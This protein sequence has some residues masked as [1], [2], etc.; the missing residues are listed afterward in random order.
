MDALGQAGQAQRAIESE[1]IAADKA[2]F[3]EARD[4][5][6]KMAQYKMGL[7]SG[8]PVATQVNTQ[9]TNPI[10]DWL[11]SSKGIA[12]LLNKFGTA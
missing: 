5:D 2:Q 3:D 6:K 1:G 11:T 9:N 12:E 7:I 4:W 10:T 8:M